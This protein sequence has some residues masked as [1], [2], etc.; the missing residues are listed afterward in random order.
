MLSTILKN[1]KLLFFLGGVAATLAGAKAVKSGKAREVCV[2]GL[3]A[4]MQFQKVAQEAF[5]NIKEEAQDL[6]QEAK[7]TAE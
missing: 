7:T 2:K 4:G 5:H 6:C 3:A 1:D